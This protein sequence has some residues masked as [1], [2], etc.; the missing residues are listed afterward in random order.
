MTIRTLSNRGM[1]FAVL[2]AALSLLLGAVPARAASAIDIEARALVAGRFEV[3]GWMALAVTLVN[4]GEP[5]EGYLIAQTEIGAVRRFVE[6]PAGARKVVMLYVQP[7]PF[8]RQVRVSYDEPN[9]S[10]TTTVDVQVL[11]QTDDQVAIV[12]DGTGT[13]RPQL[14]GS[15]DVASPEPI[16]LAPA[17]IPERPEPLAGLSAIVWAGDSAGLGEAQRRALERWVGEGGQLVILGGPDW[18]AR[19]SAFTDILPLESLAATDDVGQSALASWSGEEAPPLE[20]A[21]VSTGAMREDSRELVTAEGG[22]ILASMRPLGAGRVILIGSDLATPEYRGWEG[23][24]RLWGRLLPTNAILEQFNGGGF[25]VGEQMDS[26]MSGALATLPTLNVPPAELLLVM[27][28][29]Y[30][31]LIGPISYLVLRRIDRRELAWVTAPILIILFSACSYGVGR[32]LKGGDVVVN[33]ITLIRTAAEGGTASVDTYAGIFSPDRTTYDLSVDADALLGRLARN[34]GQPVTQVEVEQ[35]QP[36]RMHDLAIGVFGFEGVR[37]AGV[38]EHEPTLSV[39]WSARDGEVV[40]TVTNTSDTPVSDV[41]YISGSGG[42]RIGLLAPGAS[43]DFTIPRDNFNGSSAAD[44]VYGFGGFDATSEDQRRIAVR[45]QVIDALVGFA[46]FEAGGF[47]VGRRGP[48]VIGWRDEAGPM[49]ISVEGLNAQTYLSSVEVLSVRPTLGTGEVTVRPQAM[50][51]DI[52][53]TEGDANPGGPG[54]VILGDG[55][56]VYSI[57]LPLEAAD[58]VPTSVEIVIGP[59]P[60]MV[61]SE[62]GDFGDFWPAGITLELRDPTSGEWIMLGDISE[63]SAYDIEDPAMAMSDT[64]RIMVR[65][66]GVAADPNFGQQSVF[67]SATVSGVIDE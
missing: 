8:Q 38:V 45:R 42:D 43:E 10:A 49:P 27:I 18:Q 30:I 14:L 44:Q 5:T 67:A 66:T 29:G 24:P 20:T 25:P 41:A 37:A 31:L 40:G 58:M 53:S 12:G 34:D 39:A 13:L 51:V 6:M 9:G 54:T 23:A 56:V 4:D 60:S 3:G 63:K 64:G 59:D 26:A 15:G 61:L 22:E 19:T 62:P 65:I 52:V 21:T 11:E 48:Y 50:L 47:E 35:G 32:T 36:A 2:A 28:V 33:Q 1:R 57:A 17:D 7:E 55:S 46:G 16:A